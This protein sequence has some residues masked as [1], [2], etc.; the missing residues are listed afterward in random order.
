MFFYLIDLICLDGHSIG[1]INDNYL[2]LNSVKRSQ[3]QRRCKISDSCWTHPETRS[4]LLLFI[5]KSCPPRLLS[6]KDKHIIFK[7]LE[8][9]F[10]RKS[11]LYFCKW[12]VLMNHQRKSAP[13][14]QPSQRGSCFCCTKQKQKENR[15]RKKSQG[16]T[17]TTQ[18]RN[19]Q[20][21][22]SSLSFWSQIEMFNCHQSTPTIPVPCTVC[23]ARSGGNHISLLFPLTFILALLIDSIYI[24]FH[25]S[26]VQQTLKQ[27]PLMVS[28]WGQRE[29]ICIFI[30]Y[31]GWCICICTCVWKDGVFVF[32]GM[33]Y[34]YLY[35][36]GWCI[37]TCTWWDGVFQTPLMF[38][39]WG[40]RKPIFH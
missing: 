8:S 19:E 29:P 35:L 15:N 40:Q 36:V 13:F 32:G 6:S 14:T 33:V 27:I 34:L 20:Q 4:N 24:N 12:T 1:Q 37:C 22:K 39:L 9:I 16:N 3:L 18:T 21:R 38:P 25:I 5:W 11:R 23:P 7:N 26:N 30:W 10:V 2:N 31:L 17:A 28:F